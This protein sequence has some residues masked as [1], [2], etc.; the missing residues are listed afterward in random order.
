[1]RRKRRGALVLGP[2]LV[3]EHQLAL[4]VEWGVWDGVVKGS[5]ALYIDFWKWSG[6]V[7]RF[8]AISWSLGSEHFWSSWVG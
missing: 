1:V 8:W 7:G 4:V 5:S 6:E 3:K 2:G